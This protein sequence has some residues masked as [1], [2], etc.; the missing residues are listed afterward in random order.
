MILRISNAI[1]ANVSQVFEFL[2][3]DLITEYIIV[4]DVG[5]CGGFSF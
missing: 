4:K 3:A 5:Y 2:L 1:P